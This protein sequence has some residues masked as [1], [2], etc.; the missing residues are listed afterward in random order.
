MYVSRRYLLE[1]YDKLKYCM[2]KRL[3]VYNQETDNIPE[4][5]VNDILES[6]KDYSAAIIKELEKSQKKGHSYTVITKIKD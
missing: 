5:T 3:D 1:K 6:V 2:E 4:E